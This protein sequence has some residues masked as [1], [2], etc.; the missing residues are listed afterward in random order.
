MASRQR[1]EERREKVRQL[2]LEGATSKEIANS[3]KV[4]I[5]TIGK[6]RRKI[7]QDIISELRKDTIENILAEFLLKYDGIYREARRTYRATTN[8]NTKINALN[9]M[10]RHEEKKIL[11][12]QSLGVLESVPTRLQVSSEEN[13]FS[14]VEALKRIRERRKNDIEN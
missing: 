5:H 11:I 4:T 10:Q 7:K 12:L 6:D 8:D 1:V 13:N 9:L 14:V 3:L 2:V